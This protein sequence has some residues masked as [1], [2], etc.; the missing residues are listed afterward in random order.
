MLD[1]IHQWVRRW[2]RKPAEG[3]CLRVLT[4]IF[5]HVYTMYTLYVYTYHASEASG[6]R[7]VF[8]TIAVQYKLIRFEITIHNPPVLRLPYFSLG[9]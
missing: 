3:M 9:C 5:L 4:P 6:S 8:K 7:A 2:D 1:L